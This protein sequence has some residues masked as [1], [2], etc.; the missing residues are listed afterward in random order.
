MS[1]CVNWV[2]SEAHDA[3]ESEARGGNYSEARGVYVDY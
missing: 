2:K 1:R 3:L